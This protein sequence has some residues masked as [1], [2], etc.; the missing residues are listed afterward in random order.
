MGRR[1]I[2]KL[3]YYIIL[4]RLEVHGCPLPILKKATAS[5]R[6]EMSQVTNVLI[7]FRFQLV[8][9]TFEPSRSHARHELFVNSPGMCQSILY[10]LPSIR[11]APSKIRSAYH[12]EAPGVPNLTQ[13]R[14]TSAE[15]FEHYTADL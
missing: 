2:N 6:E 14:A 8:R 5:T 15:T 9:L 12:C 13:T 11:Q 1:N 10:I 3:Y 4:T 7:K